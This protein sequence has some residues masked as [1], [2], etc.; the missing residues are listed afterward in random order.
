MTG[1]KKSS[2]ATGSR[3]DAPGKPEE[4][5]D[6]PEEVVPRIDNIEAQALADSLGV[7]L[8][9]VVDD[10]KPGPSSDSPAQTAQRRLCREEDNGREVRM[11]AQLTRALTNVTVRIDGLEGQC[12][13]MSDTLTN[14]KGAQ[15]ELLNR[16]STDPDDLGALIGQIQQ[17]L[18]DELKQL[19]TDMN[20]NLE[21]QHALTAQVQ[22]LVDQ[23][24]ARPAKPDDKDDD[25]P[26]GVR[27]DEDHEDWADGDPK[28]EPRSAMRGA[29]AASSSRTKTEPLSERG[30]S[31]KNRRSGEQDSDD[32]CPEYQEEE[33]GIATTDEEATPEAGF[34]FFERQKGP[35]HPGLSSLKPANPLFDR[36]MS[37]RFYRLQRIR[38][39]VSNSTR[40]TG[41][42][43]G[44]IKRLEICFKDAYFNG[45]DPIQ[46]LEFLTRFVEEADLLN[47]SEVQ[48]YQVL[49]YFLRNPALRLYK[50]ARGRGR[51]GVTG[52]TCWPE[53]IQWLLRHFVTPSV[54]RNA[55]QDFQQIRQKP[56]ENEVTYA[57]RLQ[58]YAARCGNVFSEATQM[59]VFT[60]GLDARIRPYVARHRESLPREEA[61]LDILVS[62]ARDEGDGLRAQTGKTEKP[63]VP[64]SVHLIE[65]SA[66]EQVSQGADASEMVGLLPDGGSIATSE[67][68]S[69]VES[70]DDAVLYGNGRNDS[71]R[72]AAP[73]LAY[74][75]RRTEF[76][77]PGWQSRDPRDQRD[78]R[79]RRDQP[80]PANLDHLTCFTCYE[81]GHT[82]TNCAAPMTDYDRV[83]RNYEN[84]PP[85]RK[86]A[87]RTDSYEAASLMIRKRQERA[88]GSQAAP[89]EPEK[90]VL[91]P[92][93][94]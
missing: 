19:R 69:T 2:K 93:N 29:S 13:D 3:A 57:S 6:I 14:I 16:A 15:Q 84:L 60:D 1:S 12:A 85:D 34:S 94:E 78:N 65:G 24:Q 51:S 21:A 52:V 58:G 18:N 37:Y 8:A 82:S 32:S 10:G 20:Q 41:Q 42:T 73:Q 31:K 83:V 80:R 4:V 45:E 25:R 88:A 43:R 46:I 36:H 76:Q 71:R 64:R 9:T 81:V 22:S 72:V 87:V 61:S 48:A 28:E 39:K 70:A 53:A 91:T 35:R 63:R 23:G 7:D 55:V 79:D 67:L 49:P 50:S 11:R 33:D 75:D 56:E 66:S 62:Y 90:N 5:P 27:F 38:P 86:Q 74:A 30:R 54:L 68:P 47:M 44:F 89:A 40:E 77:R 59:S 92:K 26:A 17:P